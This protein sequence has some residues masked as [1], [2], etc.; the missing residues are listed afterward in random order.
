M[1]YTLYN[2]Q[3]K[4]SIKVDHN[5]VSNVS[6]DFSTFSS[7]EH[8]WTSSSIVTTPSLFVSISWKEKQI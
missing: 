1:T 5:T 2:E 4:F 8:H 7:L 6:R 3:L